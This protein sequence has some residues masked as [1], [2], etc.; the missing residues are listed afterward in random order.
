MKKNTLK[1]ILGALALTL[2]LGVGV[3]TV[4]NFTSNA[5]VAKANDMMTE[6]EDRKIAYNEEMAR[7]LNIKDEAQWDR[8]YNVDVA[9]E[10]AVEEAE[11]QEE[12]NNILHGLVDFE[13]KEG[14]ITAEEGRLAKRYVDA[15]SDSERSVAYNDLKDYVTNNGSSMRRYR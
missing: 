5:N 2:M 14:I 12:I 7:E 15:E 9:V 1:K 13:V 11:S 3:S 8:M 4:S 6:T 10:R